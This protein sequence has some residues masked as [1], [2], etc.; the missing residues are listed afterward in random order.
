MADASAAYTQKTIHTTLDT[1]TEEEREILMSGC[2][3]NHF[4]ND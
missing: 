4:K 1:L 3:I 2:L